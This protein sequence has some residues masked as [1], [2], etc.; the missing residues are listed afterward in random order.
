MSKNS[1]PVVL[2]LDNGPQF[3]AAKLQN[4]CTS[5]GEQKICSTPCHP[6]ENSLIKDVVCMLKKSLS[7]V[8]AENQKFFF[9]AVALAYN[10]TPR[11]STGFSLCFLTHGREATL[12]VQRHLDK[13]WLDNTALLKL[14]SLWN[15][16]VPS[17]EAQDWLEIKRRKVLA[18][19]ATLVPVGSLVMVGLIVQDKNNYLS[20]FVP[21]YM[22]PWVVVERFSNNV[23]YRLRCLI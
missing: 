17:Y 6:R 7:A 5:F 4:F 20:D 13:L 1:V 15:A 3:T 16:R 19:F 18:S 14:Q 12:P 22:G 23:T 8:I 9:S 10:S 21:M 11:V 2:M